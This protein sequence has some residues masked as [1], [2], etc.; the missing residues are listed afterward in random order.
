M[1][2]R[3]PG[4]GYPSFPKNPKHQKIKSR[5]LAIPIKTFGIAVEEKC[6]DVKELLNESRNLDEVYIK[7]LFSCSIGCGIP[8]LL[9]F[10]IFVASNFNC[11]RF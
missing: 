4:V 7:N 3:S 11:F 8:A 5:I 10:L 6:K 1:M 2:G 9:F